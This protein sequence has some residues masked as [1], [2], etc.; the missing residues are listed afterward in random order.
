VVE[1][2]LK[3]DLEIAM[4]E[5]KNSFLLYRDYLP[6]FELLTDE[7]A[8]QLIKAILIYVNDMEVPTLNPEVAIAFSF[9]KTALKRDLKKYEN[10]IDRNRENGKLGGRPTKIENPENP[11]GYLGNPKKPKKADSDSDSVI[12]SDIDIEVIKPKSKGKPFEDMIKAYT[13]NPALQ[14]SLNEFVQHRNSSAKT[15]LSELAMT[16]N[17]KELDRLFDN[18][19]DKIQSIDQTIA[20][21]WKGVFLVGKQGKKDD[22]ITYTWQAELKA[23]QDAHDAKEYK[24]KRSA[25]ELKEGFDK[26]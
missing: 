17:L 22:K 10:I 4:A 15:K 7:K 24:P 5:N 25:E 21:N 18:D 14:Q 8:G 3:K 26:L 11:V 13:D 16:K 23:E 12:E 2:S 20:N 1:K 9:I 6:Q 19:N